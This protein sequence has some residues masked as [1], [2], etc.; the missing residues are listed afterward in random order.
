VGNKNKVSPSISSST[1]SAAISPTWRRAK[2]RLVTAPLEVRVVDLVLSRVACLIW[3]QEIGIYSE[4][5]E[6]DFSSRVLFLGGHVHKDFQTI[7]D[8]VRSTRPAYQ[9]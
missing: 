9:H 5:N 2:N 6:D 8:K 7:I 1:S 4:F 3:C